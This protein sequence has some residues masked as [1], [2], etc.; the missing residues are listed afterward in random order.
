[1]NVAF[2]SPEERLDDTIAPSMQ[3]HGADLD[4][5]LSLSVTEDAFEDG[6][7]SVRDENRL[8]KELR[9]NDI[10]A[11]FVDPVISTFDGKIVDT[12][13]TSD[14]RRHMMPY[15]RVAQ[16][17]NGIVVCV[18]H[19]RKGTINDVMTNINGSS[20]FGELPRSIFGFATVGDGSNVME[21]VKN[22]AGTTGLKL[23][24]HL[25]IERGK[26]DDGQ[27][28]ELP[29]FEIRGETELSIIDLGSERDDEDATTS[30]AD[31]LWLRNYLQIEQPAPSK[32]V[33]DD[34]LKSADI[35]QSRLH[36][37]RKKLRVQIISTPKED[38]PH[39]TAW[40]LPGF[41]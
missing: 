23:E 6:L 2:Y 18:S 5:V 20:A 31:V 41:K 36:K 19:L 25:P 29:R 1:M 30:S 21:Q 12:N 33:K 7:L 3:A 13:K 24:Y 39:T 15:V 35:S 8:V 9:D 11:L 27:Y 28:Y 14:V 38:A 22:S 16:E 10:R 26:A 4:R 32:R 17:I 37:A 40:C 34:A